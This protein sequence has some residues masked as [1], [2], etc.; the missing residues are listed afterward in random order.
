MFLVQEPKQSASN[1]TIS[2][3]RNSTTTMSCL[4]LQRHEH[5]QYREEKD[6]LLAT[7]LIEDVLMLLMMIEGL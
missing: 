5:G 2:Y 4:I 3:T 7:V 6:T 1:N